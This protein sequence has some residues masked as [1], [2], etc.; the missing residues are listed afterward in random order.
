MIDADLYRYPREHFTKVLTK[1]CQRLDRNSQVQTKWK[2]RYTGQTLTE[3]LEVQRLWVAGSYARGAITCGDLDLVLEMKNLKTQEVLNGWPLAPKSVRYKLFH[4]PENVSFYYGT[5]EKNTSGVAQPDSILIWQ[6]DGFNW[7]IAIQNIQL[8][9]HAGHFERPSDKIPFGM[10]QLDADNPNLDKIVEAYEAGLVD[11][12]FIPFTED[13]LGQTIQDKD[14]AYWIVN[15]RFS[16]KTRDLVSLVESTILNK[17]GISDGWRRGWAHNTLEWGGVHVALGHPDVPINLLNNLKTSALMIVPHFKKRSP[18]GIWI[19]KRG[20]NH[21]IYKELH[22]FKLFYVERDDGH[23]KMAERRLSAYEVTRSVRLFTSLK[24]AEE[25][26]RKKT[27]ISQLNVKEL[28]TQQLME[29]IAFVDSLKVV[30][31]GKVYDFKTSQYRGDNGS[32][33]FQSKLR[34]ILS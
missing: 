28:S 3:D 13:M 20:K 24:A 16:K 26:L 5:P 18:N 32:V 14:L 10:G 2:D 33:E 8:N 17:F 12:E 30:S 19:I 6:G 25:D 23:P 27:K 34:K 1:I 29:L 21:P 9:E 31:L 4:T 22:E 7:E 11:W 15:F